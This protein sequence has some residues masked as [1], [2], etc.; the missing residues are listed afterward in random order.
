MAVFRRLLLVAVLSSAAACATL[1]DT[2][3]I[4]R[5]A[6][7]V[8]LVHFN[9]MHEMV[10]GAAGHMGGIGRLSTLV[11]RERARHSPVLVTLGG[12]FLS[13]SAIAT[14]RV[15]GEPLAGRQAVAVL[16]QLGL[17]WATF[18]NHEFDLREEAFRA[19]L[20]EIKFGLVSSNVTDN[21]GRLFAPA[22]PS[23]IV[24]L[25]AAGRD[26]RVGIVGLT[27]DFTIQPYVRYRPVIESAREQIRT[28]AGKTDAI[29][30]L[31]HLGLPGDTALA[32]ALPEIDLVLGG[33]EHDNYILRR[34]SAF[35]TL[36]KADSN[37]KS[38]AIVTM[39]FPA[40]GARPSIQAR[41]EHLNASIPPDPA[42]EAEVRRWTTTA[43]AAFARDGFSPERVVANLPEALDGRDSTVRTRPGNLT[44]LIT[45][46]IQRVAAPVDLPIMNGGSIRIDDLLA[47]G[48]ITEYDIIRILPFGGEVLRAEVTGDL[49]LETLKTGAANQGT[50]GYLHPRGAAR[51]DGEWRLHGQPIDPER[52]YSIALPEY[53]LT[54]AELGMPFLVRTSPRVRN[55]KGLGDIRQAVIA[56]LKARSTGKAVAFRLSPVQSRPAAGSLLR[57][58]AW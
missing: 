29:I 44:E 9:D 6:P 17:D 3:A 4:P 13:P 31:S 43:F 49:L 45:A 53:L 30:A 33:H 2:P 56:E 10:A 24:T 58:P 23:A 28:F 41:I 51:V 22:V 27:V 57:A 18:G 8:T 32:E 42:M 21:E 20:S 38:A 26:L 55:V 11:R 7:S 40:P 25:R 36:V 15:D 1:P 12:D 48:P 34:G 14:A 39:T 52:W 47:A 54:G 19:R 46:A 35:S 5:G 37:A 50:G 16:N